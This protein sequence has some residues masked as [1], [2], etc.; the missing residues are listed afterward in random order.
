MYHTDLEELKRMAAGYDIVPVCREIFS[1]VRTPIAVMRA[2]KHI[3]S[4]CFLLESAEG[5]KNWGRYS[6]LGFDPLLS[7]TCKNHEMT[8]KNSETRRFHTDDPAGEIRRIL[9]E[10]KSP[11]IPDLPPFT[12]GLVGYF[13][14]EY[15]RYIEPKLDF[16]E[17]EDTPFQDVDLMLFDKIIAFDHLKQK[18]FLIVN[19][20]TDDLKKNYNKVLRVLNDMADLAAHGTES[21]IPAGKLLS[22]FKNEFTQEE[23]EEVVEKVKHYIREGDIFQAVPSN[24]RTAAFSGSLFDAYRVLKTVNPSPYMFY[25]SGREIELTGASPETLVRLQDGRLRT[26]PIAGT[27]P[28]GKTEEEDKALEAELL[29][30]KKELAEHDMLVDLGR[31]DIGKISRFGTVEVENFHKIE[32][33]SHV[34]HLTSTVTG[35]IRDGMDALDAVAA[36]LPAGTLS[37]APKIRAMEILH[38]LEK[39]PRGI[40]GG[41][42]GYIDFTG[43]MDVCI[44]IRMAAAAK[45]KVFIRSGGGIVADSIP[46][47]EFEETVNKSK[48]MMEA[49]TM[50]QEVKDYDFAD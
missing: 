46:K 23:Y 34:M 18:M 47:E 49:I 5:G 32:R 50:A 16:E 37:G 13:A 14:Y 36:T 45:G 21:E 27:N 33:F 38:E 8:I 28:R 20:R 6:F 30:D 40:Y 19:I 24:C 42:I 15:M 43:N 12:G 3:S 9:Q 22:P 26:F 7:V 10:Y 25:F 44:G 2:L 29:Q 1:D 4:C 31:N 48:A 41:A 17:K 35:E 11:R 39:S